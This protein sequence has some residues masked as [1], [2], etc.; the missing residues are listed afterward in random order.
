MFPIM[1]NTLT[2]FR[3]HFLTSWNFLHRQSYH[4]CIET[5]LFLPSQYICTLLL[6]LAYHSARTSSMMMNRKDERRHLCL[7]PDFRRKAF[8]LSP[9]SMMLTV[10]FSCR[11][12]LSCTYS[13][14][15]LVSFELLSLMNI[16]FCQTIY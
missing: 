2:S 7:V 11:F 16:E 6:F 12:L 9:L 14:L 5:G 3:R 13:L 10:S 1:L 8:S 15:F 4:L